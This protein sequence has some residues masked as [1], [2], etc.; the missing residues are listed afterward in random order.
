MNV[1]ELWEALE[2]NISPAYALRRKLHQFPDTSGNEKPTLNTMLDSLPR[3]V[4]ITETA[5]TGAVA[6]L[7]PPGPSIGIRGELDAL[8]VTEATA[9]PWA[10]TNHGVMHACGHDVHLAALSAVM[11]S[12]ADVGA[13]YPILAVLQ[14]REE[15]YPS[16]AQD[17]ASSGILAA[18]ECQAMLGAHVQPTLAQGVV[19]CVPGGVNAASDEF[20]VEIVGSPGHAAYPHLND[21]PLLA[22][23]EIVL[24]LQSIVSR[25]IDPMRS[26][27]LGVSSFTAG[28][29]ANVV[30]HTAR[31]TGIL[32]ALD[33]DTRN[34]LRDRLKRTANSVAEAHDCR[35]VVDITPGEPVLYNDPDLVSFTQQLLREHGN[36]VSTSL[37][38][39]GADDFSFYAETIPSLMLFV[40]TSTDEYLHTSTFLPN[41]QDVREVARSM[42]SAYLGAAQ[43]LERKI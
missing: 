3:G 36:E 25:R 30:P 26:A 21:D 14:P 28:Q 5:E 35:S 41:D 33:N 6:R 15:T 9:V 19:A 4:R 38:S 17:I 34:V 16:G 8:P 10:S 37:R 22:A 29:A 20:S 27:V 7:G 31:I 32:R 1:T 39:L 43:S 24:S 12:L 23:S 18:E 11:H 40:G 42:L 2:A 13:P